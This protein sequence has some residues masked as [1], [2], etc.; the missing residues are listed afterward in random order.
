MLLYKY[1][2]ILLLANKEQTKALLTKFAETYRPF[3]LNNISEFKQFTHTKN[4]T[5]SGGSYRITLI[6]PIGKV[7]FD[8]PSDSYILDASEEAGI[9]LP[10]G[11]RSGADYISAGKLVSGTVQM[12]DNI[13]TEEQIKGGYVLLD[14]SYPT[15]DCVIE[16]HKE[17]ELYNHVC[18]L[19]E[20]EINGH[21]PDIE[22]PD[23]YNWDELISEW[24]ITPGNYEG[25][26][27]GGETSGPTDDNNYPPGYNTL[28]S[29]EKDFIRRHPLAA[30]DFYKN[31]ERAFE[32]THNMQIK[33][34]Y[35]IRLSH[36]GILDCYRHV[37]WCALNAFDQGYELAKEYGDAHEEDENAP[38]AEREM[39]LYNNSLGYQIGIYAKS[40]GYSHGEIPNIVETVVILQ[41]NG[42]ILIGSR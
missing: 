19:P 36:N 6:T 30:I 26:G 40:N 31:S 20:V 33:Y 28:T 4:V 13:L 1:A 27:G 22:I 38:A 11:S 12:D 15:S 18:E 2:V 8:C 41:G 10:Y 17:D 29:K 35:D 7:Q 3:V 42:K 25:G 37:L 9:D 5:R 16:T 23:D 24:M 14:V 39:D 21:M 34:N 32:E